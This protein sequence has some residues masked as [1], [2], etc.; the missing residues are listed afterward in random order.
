MRG[1]SASM[2][3]AAAIKKELSMLQAE[4][5]A[6]AAA[7]GK[8]KKH[9][10]FEAEYQRWYT[11]ALPVVKQ[12][13]PDRYAEF[14]S[15]YEMGFRMQGHWS[16]A[17][18]IQHYIK[19]ID[20]FV[21]D[22]YDIR[23]LAA[24][25]F[26]NQLAIFAALRA[27]IDYALLDAEDRIQVELQTAALETARSLVRISARAAGALAGTVLE[28]HL[29]KLARKHRART[30]KKR[31][32]IRDLND[33]LQRAGVLD[34]QLWSQ[35]GWLAD[36]RD[37]CALKQDTPPKKVQARDLIDGTHWLIKNIF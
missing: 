9:A 3:T 1:E 19:G 18:A 10:S 7:F 12:V 32:G 16:H 31:P 8:G 2:A 20:P 5:E 29:G 27:R 17:Y 21:G 36:I 23:E 30:F 33:A 35:I 6:L 34:A 15:Y 25:C 28:T 11:R 13:A 4:G 14:R 24:R 22:D 26:S 37:R